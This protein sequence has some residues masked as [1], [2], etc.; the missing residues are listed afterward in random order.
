MADLTSLFDIV[1]RDPHPNALAGLMAILDV[2]GAPAPALSGTPTPGN[3]FP[4]HLVEMDGNGEAVLADGVGGGTQKLW[5]VA[6][7]GDRDYDGAFLHRLTCLQGGGELST[8]QYHVGS[9]IITYTPGAALTAGDGAG[10][11]YATDTTGQFI[12]AS[13][14]GATAQVYGFVGPNGVNANGTLDVLLP[15]GYGR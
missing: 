3:I 12:L 4:G 8:D 7:D 1:T 13:A 2:A 15:Q 9:P 14:V 10:T 11:T 5:F 6:V